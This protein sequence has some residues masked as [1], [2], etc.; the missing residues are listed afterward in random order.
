M[1]VGLIYALLSVSVSSGALAQTLQ[2]EIRNLE[3]TLN[4]SVPQCA[5]FIYPG[6]MLCHRQYRISF[7]GTILRI[8]YLQAGRVSPDYR[9]SAWREYVEELNVKNLD[10]SRTFFVHQYYD[11]P[12][13]AVGY[14]DHSMSNRRWFFT[15]KINCRRPN[16][17]RVGNESNHELSLG[18]LFSRD[19]AQEVLSH[20]RRIADFLN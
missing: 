20:F 7:D 17:H 12:G 10:F 6:M 5:Y 3:M 13:V 9:F 11:L 4:K 8:K 14:G 18:P 15:V 16:C 2:R 1:R 19:D